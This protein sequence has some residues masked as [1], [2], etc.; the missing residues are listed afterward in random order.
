MNKFKFEI[1]EM[2]ED[3]TFTG[4]ASMYGNLD[5]GGDIVEKGAFTKTLQE[6][7]TVPIL[8]C[9]KTDMPI[10]IGELQDTESGLIINGKLNLEVEKA[11][12]VYALIKQG[13]IKGL[14]IGYDVVK[15][16]YEKGVRLLKELKLWEVSVVTFPMNTLSTIFSV[17]EDIKGL[18]MQTTLME[19]ESRNKLWKLTDLLDTTI[20]NILCK[21]ELEG[22]TKVKLVDNALSQ[23]HVL[24]MNAITFNITNGIKMDIIKENNEVDIN[25]ILSEIKEQSIIQECIKTLNTMLQDEEEE[26]VIESVIDNSKSTEPLSEEV[27]IEKI[28]SIFNEMKMF[29][30]NK[31][32]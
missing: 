14:S 3:G 6:K 26:V 25:R 31:E 32:D 8:W 28:N 30:N 18:D 1:K 4:V 27:D 21:Q 12:E 15:Q 2:L 13:A 20:R 9:H 11:K 5:L 23:F 24:Y 29:F 10:G 19:E 17:K 16:K 22:D 7:T